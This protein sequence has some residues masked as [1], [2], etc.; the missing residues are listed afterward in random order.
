MGRRIVI[1]Q[2]HHTCHPTGAKKGT[3]L[4]LSA[5]SRVPVL[6]RKIFMLGGAGDCR[7]GDEGDKGD[8]EISARD[9]TLLL[10]F[11]PSNQISNMM[12]PRPRPPQARPGISCIVVVE[13]RVL[14]NTWLQ[15]YGGIG[16]LYNMKVFPGRVPFVALL[17]P[18]PL[19][20]LSSVFSQTCHCISFNKSP[21]AT[22]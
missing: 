3:L 17:F 7:Q 19:S 1:D 12:P 16:L 20:L 15:Q 21:T 13:S 9:F 8:K 6:V 11:A 2:G 14:V 18:C 4:A 10:E 22:D 5:H